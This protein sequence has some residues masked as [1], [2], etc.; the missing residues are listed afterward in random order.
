[1]KCGLICARSARTSAR[2]RRCRDASS[3][4]SSS[5]PET[6]LATSSVARSKPAERSVRERHQGADH[7]VLDQQRAG[8]GVPDEAPVGRAG[9]VGRSRHHGGGGLDGTSG[10]VV[11]LLL[12]VGREPVVP[13]E[14]VGV[15]DRDGGSPEQRAQVLEAAADGLGVQALAEGGGGQR[16]RVQRAEGG[17]VGVAAELS[18]VP[19]AAQ[20]LERHGYTVLT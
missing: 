7:A 19:A 11:R 20:P 1:M 17:E 15:G 13:Q 3:S 2:I 4:A 14:V 18:G 16:S 5:W 9:E 10:D 12:V 6:Q 8:D